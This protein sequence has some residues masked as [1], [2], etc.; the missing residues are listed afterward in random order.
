MLRRSLEERFDLQNGAS[1]PAELLAQLEAHADG[2]AFAVWAPQIDLAALARLRGGQVPEA[3]AAGHSAAWRSLDLAALHTVAIDQLF[4]EGTS[5]LSESGLLSYTRALEDVERTVG[6]AEA[7]LA[8]LVRR[9]PVEQIL[10]VADAGDLMPEK[11]TY[12]Y[13]KPVTGM[14]ISNLEGAV[15]LS[16]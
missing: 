16:A 6:S 11:S 3:L 8:F 13:P 10:S 14:V 9:T 2:P 4:P 7:D 5:A 12:F 15:A 1:S